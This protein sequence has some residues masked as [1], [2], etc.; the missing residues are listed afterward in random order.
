[1]ASQWKTHTSS[2][3]TSHRLSCGSIPSRT[4]MMFLSLGVI[5]LLYH[6]CV[7]LRNLK[8]SLVRPDSN[9]YYPRSH[10]IREQEGSVYNPTL[11]FT[12]LGDTALSKYQSYLWHSVRQAR[13]INPTITM[14]IIL[15]KIQYEANRN[16]I[17]ERLDHFRISP[18][19]HED[20][21][22]SSQLLKTFREIFFVAGAMEPDGNKYFV[23]YAIE[24]LICIHAYINRTNAT[25]I[26]HIE[27]D[28]MLYIDLKNLSHRMHACGVGFA[29]PRASMNQAVT[30]FVYVRSVKDTE[31]FVKW[32][33]DIFRLGPQGATRYINDSW[34][35]D[36]TLGARYLQLHAFSKRQSELSG[37]Y[38]LPS[39]FA[40]AEN[41]HCILQPS[42]TEEPIIFDA[43]VIGQYF[44][45]TFSEPN[46]S[47][48]HHSRLIDPRGKILE[49]RK[50]K[51]DQ[52][53]KPFI[54][55]LRIV[56]LHVHSKELKRFSSEGEGQTVRPVGN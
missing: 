32:C 46:V 40:K 15:S 25:D 34:L 6:L 21:I 45:G 37:V 11:V 47:Y 31:K 44:G 42:N 7:S 33:I 56:N 22:E 23:Q 10:L 54:N 52:L 12:C 3:S 17:R 18:I 26:F 14:V 50:D 9:N 48:W 4:A 13:L 41:N 5:F 55:S 8:S 35:N 30:S 51:I 24:R 29:F 27:N 39:T 53:K 16:T 1:M 43:C 20:L 19:F 38:E 28:N 36:M 2:R 49:W